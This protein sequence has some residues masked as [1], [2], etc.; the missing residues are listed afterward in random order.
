MEEGQEPVAARQ[1]VAG[2]WHMQ[3]GC[4]YTHTHTHSD[5][6]EVFWMPDLP[7]IESHALNAATDTLILPHVPNLPSFD[8]R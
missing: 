6:T 2:S 7:R 1:H 8:L 5:G 4:T 3:S